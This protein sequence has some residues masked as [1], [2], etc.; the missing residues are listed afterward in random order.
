VTPTLQPLFRNIFNCDEE[1]FLLTA[2]NLAIGGLQGMND[3]HSFFLF[4]TYYD[5]QL[6]RHGHFSKC[7]NYQEETGSC[8]T[9][10]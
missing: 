6:V 9:N 10:E 2:E 3:S 8:R 1:E 4:S 5:N 7:V